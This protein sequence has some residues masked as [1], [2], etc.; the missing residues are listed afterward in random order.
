FSND[1]SYSRIIEL[2]EGENFVS[3]LQGTYDRWGDYFGLQRKY[4]EPET[5]YGSG[6]YGLPS[7]ASG[8]WIH[9]LGSPDTAKIHLRI[10]PTNNAALCEGIAKSEIQGGKPPYFYQWVSHPELDNMTPN[11]P[12]IFGVCRDDTVIL[13][14]TDQRGTV[15]RDSFVF[16]IDEKDFKPE[17]YPNPFEDRFMVQFHLEEDAEVQVFLYRASGQ[18]ISEIIKKDVKKGL[19]EFTFSTSTIERG[20]YIIRGL[21]DGKEIFIRR[22]IKAVN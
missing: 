1:S 13:Q 14:V 2:K 16:P 5:V 17:V 20:Q 11:S 4:N 8:T 7:N 15:V 10:Y 22:I 21:V 19:N 18:I 12:D 3:R 6:F 9:K